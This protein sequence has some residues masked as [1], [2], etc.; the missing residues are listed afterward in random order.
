MSGVVDVLFYP[1]CGGCLVWWMS[2]FAHGVVD[3]WCGRCLCGGCRT[4]VSKQT[5]W[6]V[7]H[8]VLSGS[9][10]A[11]SSATKSPM[12][13]ICFFSLCSHC[14]NLHPTPTILQTNIMN[15]L[16]HKHTLA[17]FLGRSM[18]ASSHLRSP[19]TGCSAGFLLIVQPPPPSYTTQTI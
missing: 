19:P 14:T 11:G 13:E 5:Y 4:I 18:L 15:P 9:L 16:R 2:F 8:W 17:P 7:P 6:G 3:V 12:N 10:S 1:W